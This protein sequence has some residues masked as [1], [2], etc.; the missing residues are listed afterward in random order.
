MCSG[1]VQWSES[2]TVTGYQ[3]G[4]MVKVGRHEAARTAGALWPDGTVRPGG[5]VQIGTVQPDGMVRPGGMVHI[6]M[7]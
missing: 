6:G 3:T 5:V 2:P 7:V 4:H 1:K